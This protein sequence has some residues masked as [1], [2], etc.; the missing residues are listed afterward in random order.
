MLKKFR[1]EQID[2]SAEIAKEIEAIVDKWASEELMNKIVSPTIAPENKRGLW[3]RFKG[4]LSNIWYG[5]RGGRYNPENP[6]YWKNRF[7]DDLGV[8]ESFNPSVFTIKEYKE[9]RSVIE[10]TEQ[11]I[12]ESLPPGA[13]K[14]RIV[15]IIKQAAENL[16]KQLKDIFARKCDVES[17]S[18]P[19]VA[20]DANNE[21]PAKPAVAGAPIAQDPTASVEPRATSG[22]QPRSR[23]RRQIPPTQEPNPTSNP[24]SNPTPEPTPEPEAEEKI[25]PLGHLSPEQREQRYQMALPKEENKDLASSYLMR[26]KQIVDGVLVSDFEKSMATERL[27]NMLKWVKDKAEGKEEEKVINKIK[28]AVE[29]VERSIESDNK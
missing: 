15:Q 28:K 27:L 4:G 8:K 21:E 17:P 29:K 18:S 26:H 19:V 2:A 23:R 7:G 1:E 14:L 5:L 10:A 25:G 22:L 24:T 16:K 3:D 13:D 6:Y 9:I 20:Q 11:Q 12:N